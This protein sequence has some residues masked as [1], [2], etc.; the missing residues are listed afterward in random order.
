MR[1]AKVNRKL[2]SNIAF[3]GGTPPVVNVTVKINDGLYEQL[4]AE[5]DRLGKPMNE[6]IIDAL[7]TRLGRPDLNFIPRKAMGRPRKHALA[8][9][10]T[11]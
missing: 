4:A 3:S 1:A 11:D 8:A 10:A 6:V 5:A 7:A 9:A 2:S